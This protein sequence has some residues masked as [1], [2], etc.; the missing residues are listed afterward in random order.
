LWIKFQV[1]L[2]SPIHPPLG[3]INCVPEVIREAVESRMMM[4][5]ID[6]R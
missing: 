4:Y 6:Y 5:V 2:G 3:A 1:F